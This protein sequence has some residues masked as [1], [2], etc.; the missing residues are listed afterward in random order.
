MPGEASIQSGALL[1]GK[2]KVLDLLGQGGMGAVYLAENVDIGRQVAIKV[3]KPELAADPSSLARFKQ[4]ARAAAAIG[5]PGI[6]E[7]LDLGVLP[8]GGAFIVMERLVGQTLRELLAAQGSLTPG[9]AAS[10]I[11]SVL[12]TLA[13]AHDAGVIHRDLKPDNIFLA[14]QPVPGTKILDFGI[15]KFRGQG[16]VALTRTGMVMGT[17]LYMS[18]EQ[19]RGAKDVGQ[20]ADIYSIGAI[21][22]EA[23]SG[24]PPFPGES[25]NEVLAKVLMDTAVPLGQLRADVPEPLTALI[26]RMLGKDPASRPQTARDA[27]VLLRASVPEGLAAPRGTSATHVRMVPPTPSPG[28][29]PAFRTGPKPAAPA[30]MALDATYTPPPQD[31]RASKAPAL[32]DTLARPPRPNAAAPTESHD[33]DVA[34]GLPRSRLPLVLGVGA[35]IIA[36]VLLGMMLGKHPG[37]LHRQLHVQVDGLDR[38]ADH[39]PPPAPAP[40]AVAPETTVAAPAPAAEAKPPPPPVEAPVRRVAKQ[41]ATPVRTKPPPRETAHSTAPVHGQVGSGHKAP[42]HRGGNDGMSLPGFVRH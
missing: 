20:T 29:V 24:Q 22:Y 40:V 23:L 25:Y 32:P 17:P 42:V 4:E 34:R 5:H 7:I 31:P 3:L 39:A 6:V 15:S 41:P 10:V 38:P 35:A 8:D 18:P 12:G 19:A 33:D 14:S 26:E 9:E 36:A 13:A 30:P 2:Y 37:R 28:S 11:G 21:L 1:A 27:A 16:D